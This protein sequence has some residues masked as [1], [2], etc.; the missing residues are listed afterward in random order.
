MTDTIATWP[1][2]LAAAALWLFALAR[3]G[4]YYLVG[5]ISR[6]RPGG[7]I[8]QYAQRASRGYLAQAERTVEE[9]GPKAVV[10]GYPF[11]GVSAATQIIAGGLRMQLVPFYVALAVVALPW[12]ILQAT[13]GVAV[14]SAFM[15]GYAPWVLGVAAVS[16]LAWLIGR[17][18]RQGRV[19]GRTERAYP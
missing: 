10:L 17:S 15:A 2:P 5:L 7:R 13:V 4:G 11:V 18:R 8:D 14:L 19:R 16:A 1:L 3:G 6:G 9:R 12:A